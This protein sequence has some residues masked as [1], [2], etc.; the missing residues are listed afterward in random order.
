MN[1]NTVKKTDIQEIVDNLKEDK[2]NAIKELKAAT[3]EEEENY[4]NG[5]IRGLDWAITNF[6]VNFL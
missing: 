1:K 6:E 4:F 3:T 2:E 5:L